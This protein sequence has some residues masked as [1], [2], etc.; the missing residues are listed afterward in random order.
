VTVI[1]VDPAD[2][3][4]ADLSWCFVPPLLVQTVSRSRRTHED[5]VVAVAEAANGTRARNSESVCVRSAAH[6]V[7]VTAA[8]K[9][10]A[11]TVIPT[12]NTNAM[13][14]CRVNCMM[15]SPCSE[16]VLSCVPGTAGRLVIVVANRAPRC[17]MHV[18][19][20]CTRDECPAT[21]TRDW[22]RREED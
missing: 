3:L 10:V 2:L 16:A 15:V 14:R 20:E 4:A 21:G 11:V 17:L 9:P 19:A 13:T 1:G 7:K 6:V 12:A 5:I 22:L 8:N 18:S